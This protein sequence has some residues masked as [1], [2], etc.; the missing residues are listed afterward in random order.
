M[1]GVCPQDDNV[2]SHGAFPGKPIYFSR[3][4]QDFQQ[5]LRINWPWFSSKSAATPMLQ[6]CNYE[7]QLTRLVISSYFAQALTF[8]LMQKPAH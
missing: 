2:I 7:I 3:E 6:Q 8:K 1:K 4:L 5:F